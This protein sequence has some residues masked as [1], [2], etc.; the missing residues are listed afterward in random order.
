LKKPIY[1]RWWF[2]VGA[3]ILIIIIANAGGNKETI[4]PVAT[5]TVTPTVA[6]SVAPAVSTAPVA[7]VAPTATPAPTAPPKPINKGTITKAEFDEIQ[8]G[9][10]YDQVSKIIGGPGE[11]MSEVGTKGEQ[12]YTVMYMYKGEGSLGSNANLMFQDGKLNTKAQ[13]GLK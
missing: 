4:Q 11:V 9:M 5:T 10:S 7:T 2:W 12:F 1:K 8:N 13:F 6:P 3:I